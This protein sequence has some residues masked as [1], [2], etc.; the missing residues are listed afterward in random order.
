[1]NFRNGESEKV[2]EVGKSLRDCTFVAEA[3]FGLERVLLSMKK[4]D[5]LRHVASDFST[6][7]SLAGAKNKK[8]N[9]EIH[10]YLNG[11]PVTG[12]V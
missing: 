4:L 1:M 5:G 10:F 8:R 12:A 11:P 9:C 6:M 2:A 7:L 3:Y